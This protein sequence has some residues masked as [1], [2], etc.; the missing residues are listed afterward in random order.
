MVRWS[1]NVSVWSIFYVY[2][3]DTRTRQ[4]LPTLQWHAYREKL[5]VAYDLLSI[6]RING[7]GFRVCIIRTICYSYS[8]AKALDPDFC[9]RATA[10]NSEHSRKICIYHLLSRMLCIIWIRPRIKLQ[11]N[12]RCCL[13]Q[14]F[15]VTHDFNY[16][17]EN[18]SRKI[19][20]RA[21][22]LCRNRIVT[23]ERACEVNKKES[24]E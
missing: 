5:I 2:Q 14:K 3:Y 7:A 12:C 23:T 9:V 17:S 22:V 4:Y 8:F 18:K 11:I 15:L 1:V 13:F 20:A 6:L 19:S 21:D 24:W 16:V 10:N